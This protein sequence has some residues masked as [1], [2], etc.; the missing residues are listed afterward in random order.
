MNKF[1]YFTDEELYI[2]KRQALIS[3]FEIVC[4]DKYIKFKQEIHT[5]LMHD[6]LDEIV[7]RG[8]EK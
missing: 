8:K 7:R 3:S 1:E 6:I 2:L 5:Q 4:S